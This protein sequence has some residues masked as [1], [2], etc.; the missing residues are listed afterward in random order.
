MRRWKQDQKNENEKDCK[1]KRYKE[2]KQDQEGDEQEERLHHGTA[3]E[4]EREQ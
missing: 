2:R 4:R 1:W 3:E